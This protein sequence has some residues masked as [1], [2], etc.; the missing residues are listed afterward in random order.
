MERR[1]FRRIPGIA[2]STLGLASG[3]V[4][5]VECWPLAVDTS[6]PASSSSRAIASQ[7][8]DGAPTA[9]ASNDLSWFSFDASPRDSY[10]QQDDHFLTFEPD[11][12][13][14]TV[15]NDQQQT[16][17]RLQRHKYRELPMSA[18][19]M[20]QMHRVARYYTALL[21][22]DDRQALSR[23][24][25]NHNLRKWS[26]E[27]MVNYHQSRKSLVPHAMHKVDKMIA[28]ADIEQD[29]QHSQRAMT[30]TTDRVRRRRFR[31]PYIK[32]TADH[33]KEHCELTQSARDFRF[34]RLSPNELPPAPTTRSPAISPIAFDGDLSEPL[35]WH[36]H[37][38]SSG[39]YFSHRPA[40]RTGPSHHRRTSPLASS[41]GPSSDSST[42]IRSP[43]AQEVQFPHNP[44][45]TFDS[46]LVPHKSGK[47]ETFYNGLA[48]TKK[49]KFPRLSKMP[50]MPLLRK[51]AKPEY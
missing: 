11:S 18:F 45:V 8:R 33:D 31:L 44:V 21:S 12:A 5:E 51:R 15:T 41:S 7:Q 20:Q 10:E 28:L 24:E 47:G 27:D 46:F 2:S 35:S 34:P 40:Y 39:D 19:P 43:L 1:D 42:R 23:G 37:A 29:K 17:S 38:A 9:N 22:D 26:A 13:A 36:S 48:N 14:N 50:S 30:V 32:V 49:S 16:I 25:K 6:G 4:Q 3:E